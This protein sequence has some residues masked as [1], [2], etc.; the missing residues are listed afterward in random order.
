MEY[1]QG[2]EAVHESEGTWVKAGKEFVNMASV[3]TVFPKRSAAGGYEVYFTA[4]PDCLD[5]TDDEAANILAYIA[6]HAWTGAAHV[7]EKKAE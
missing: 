6:S 2:L 1:M 4:D 3:V 7:W 5:L